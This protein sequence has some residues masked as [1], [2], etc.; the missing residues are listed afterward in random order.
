M[1]R[2]WPDR[3]PRF[4]IVA[5]RGTKQFRSGPSESFQI[6]KIEQDTLLRD[7]SARFDFITVRYHMG[8]QL[9]AV[10]PRSAVTV[11]DTVTH[12]ALT[13]LYW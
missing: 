7:S 13:R 8:S 1:A 5:G 11:P 4:T 2:W 10:L 3:R 12:A 6:A 9:P